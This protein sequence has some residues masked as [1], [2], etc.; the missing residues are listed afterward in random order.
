[1]PKTPVYVVLVDK[2]PVCKG[3]RL[4]RML[5]EARKKYP[6]KKISIR[7]EYPEETLVARW[8]ELRKKEGLDV[9]KKMIYGDDMYEEVK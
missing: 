3:K 5:E 4:K 9:T 7:Y 1:M 6:R 8:D 2:K